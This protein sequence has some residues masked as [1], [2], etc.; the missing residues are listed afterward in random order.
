MKYNSDSLITDTPHNIIFN[1]SNIRLNMPMEF[2]IL[3]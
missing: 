1:V 2:T 3:K